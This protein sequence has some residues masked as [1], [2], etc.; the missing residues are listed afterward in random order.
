[1]DAKVAQLLTIGA[2]DDAL[3]SAGLDYWL[4]GGWA[5]EFHV[6]RVTRPHGDI[7]LAVWLRQAPEIESLLVAD[8]WNHAPAADEDGGTGYERD[9]IRV[10]LTFL[11]EGDAGEVLIV[12]R[13]GTAVWSS[14]PFGSEVR[15]LAGSRA[16]V[17]PVDVLRLGK[18]RPRDDARQGALDRA[19]YRVLLDSLSDPLA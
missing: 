12:F 7:D 3:E 6:G 15:E 2:I 9:G 17:V 1:V 4:F 19:D 5:V 18:S 11:E 14:Q 10:E 16:R 8:G 13:G